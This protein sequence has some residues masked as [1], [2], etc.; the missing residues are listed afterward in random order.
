MRGV[1]QCTTDIVALAREILAEDQPGAVGAYPLAGWSAFPKCT[2]QPMYL[3]AK[4]G[5]V[6]RLYHTRNHHDLLKRHASQQ[7]LKA[8]VFCRFSRGAP[9]ARWP[10]F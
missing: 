8:A 9:A 7:P 5:K 3:Q 1:C 2:T 6:R 4:T 10:Y